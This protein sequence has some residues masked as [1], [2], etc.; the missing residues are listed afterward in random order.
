MQ[1]PTPETDLSR[2]AAGETAPWDRVQ[3]APPPAWADAGEL[4]DAGFR[5]KTDAHVTQLLWSWQ[6]D[7]ES[8]QTFATTARRLETAMAVQHESQWSLDLDAR[9]SRLTLHWLRI[10][11]GD[12][13]IDQL[14]RERMRLL[15][16]ETQ[17]EHHVI[18]GSW[19]LLLVLEDV[20]PGDVIEAAYTTEW[21]HPIRP[22]GCEV[23]FVV[24]PRLSVG[25]Y[26]LAVLSDPARSNL[27][28]K[29]SADAPAHHE[30]SG[31]A[32]RRRWVWEGSQPAPREPEPNQPTT[33][34]D[35]LW[36]Q[37]SDLADWGELAVRVD[38]AWTASGEKSDAE[39]LAAFAKP[40]KLDA[41][42][43]AGLVRQIQDGFRYLS[44]NLETGG[45]I[46]ASPRKTA[47][48]RH[49][50]CKD[51]AWLAA[52]VLRGW[53]VVARPVLVGTGLR[54][55]VA[56]LLPMSIAF[57]HAI[58]E[59]EWDGAKRWFD[60]TSRDQGG[61]FETQAVGWFGRGLV[62]DARDG[63]LRAQPGE[64]IGGAYSVKETILLDSNRQSVSMVEIRLRAEGMQA[65]N[66][67]GERIARGAEAFSRE[68][69]DQARRRH[70][71]ARRVG[72]L[73]WRDDRDR[74]VCE[75]VE[76]FEIGHAVYPGEQG[77]R[78]TYDAPTSLLAQ[79]FLLP[80][81]VARRGPWDMPFPLEVAHEIMI[82]SPALG[83][84]SSPRRRWSTPEFE[85]MIEG[86]MVRGAW[87][88][89]MRFRVGA[90]EIP[91]ERVAQY[92][93]DL[94]SVFRDLGW[95][96]YVP[97]GQP[98][99]RRGDRF[100]ELG[101]ESV[102]PV[103]GTALSQSRPASVIAPATSAPAPLAA[104]VQPSIPR[105]GPTPKGSSSD[106]PSPVAEPPSTEAL[107]KAEKAKQ[108][109]KGKRRRRTSQD[110]RLEREPRNPLPGI[111]LW[112]LI[113]GVLV[114]A[115][116]LIYIARSLA[117]S[118]G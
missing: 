27:R 99:P 80:D 49:G 70:G 105:P 59:V 26:H 85:A 65:D 7:A 25:R 60:L 79:G 45:W 10:V 69:E 2:A 14:N 72:E 47:R 15:Q 18:D 19:T 90:A 44:I 111:P 107:E 113:V 95:R 101:E 88:K 112:V 108:S 98:R 4:Y 92:R 62:I 67:R 32:G 77:Q 102:D 12:T 87:T 106:S 51:L 86:S 68:R 114:I 1:A 34:I 64:R 28:W 93:R 24:P 40:A 78:A 8:G 42:A 13:R 46:P 94:E 66:L 75:L 29:A 118:P 33:F 20:Q 97:W 11:R 58:L 30:E 50:D 53:G 35:N 103:G 36:V 37:V 17:L 48:Q 74:N 71:R 73:R 16:R 61:G 55:R 89:R 91:A 21:R 82:K 109:S 96:V 3:I 84:G 57:N 6:V 9:A 56:D 43:I 52:S 110:K 76:V 23:F 81:D 100:G 22:E 117:S 41:A 63:G 54:E 104:A 83:V 31:P 116:V 39:Q 5:G 38:A 115:A